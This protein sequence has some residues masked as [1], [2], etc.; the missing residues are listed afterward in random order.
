MSYAWYNSIENE[1]YDIAPE[2]LTAIERANVNLIP[3]VEG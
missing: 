2:D 1:R 3:S